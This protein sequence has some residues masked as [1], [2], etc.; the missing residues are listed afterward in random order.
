MATR[1]QGWAGSSTGGTCYRNEC[2]LSTCYRNFCT[3][4]N[5]SDTNGSTSVSSRI[6]SPFC[7]KYPPFIFIYKRGSKA[8]HLLHLFHISSSYIG[9]SKTGGSFYMPQGQSDTPS[10]HTKGSRRANIPITKNQT[11][12]VIGT[13]AQ[14]CTIQGLRLPS[15]HQLKPLSHT[16][17]QTKT[18]AHPH[19]EASWL[20]TSLRAEPLQVEASLRCHR[21][22]RKD[23]Q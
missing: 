1:Y 8:K 6:S 21:D 15:R 23:D 2:T 22:N 20:H 10:S 11:R 19:S 12:L 4:P 16:S 3:P 5:P 18:N 13:S 7:K 14:L 17:G 9:L